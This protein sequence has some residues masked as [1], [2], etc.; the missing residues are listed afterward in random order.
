[1]KPFG[2][3]Y[4][5]IDK[6]NGMGYVGQT[7]QTLKARFRQHRTNKRH[8]MHIDNMIRACSAK[9]FDCHVLRECA[10]Q[11]ELNF[12]E[13]FFIILLGTKI[14][15][16]YNL[17]DGGDGGGHHSQET[18]AQM[19][20]SRRGENNPAYN[21]TSSQRKSP[22]KNLLAAM[23]ER[24]INTYRELAELMGISVSKLSRKMSGE[25]Y[26]TDD[27]KSFLADYLGKPIEYLFERDDGKSA[28][29]NRGNPAQNRG[30]CP[31]PNI[32]KEMAKCNLQ[33]YDQL[34]ERADIPPKNFGRKMNGIRNFTNEDKVKISNA[35]GETIEY[36]FVR[37]DGIKVVSD[38]GRCPYNNLEARNC[39]TRNF[40]PYARK[41]FGNA[42]R[43]TF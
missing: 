25:T 6:T 34:A 11:G 43:N 12:W 19:S 3:V 9:N 27:E 1:M 29:S 31:Y 23:A 8:D 2:I 42:S 14:P 36:L 40:A 5:L 30:H 7:T 24:G 32:L 21:K 4:L 35:L 17:K 26:F 28:E 33:T 15:N 38:C 18:C 10:T 37:D 22:Y 13:Q 41:T 20:E 16:G 39:D